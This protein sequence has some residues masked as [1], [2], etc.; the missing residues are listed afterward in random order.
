MTASRRSGVKSRAV[1]RTRARNHEGVLA[2]VP[3]D[4][5]RHVDTWADAWLRSKFTRL[6]ELRAKDPGPFNYPVEVFSEWRGKSFYICARYRTNSGRPEN[7]FIHR[8]ARLT[9]TGFERFDLSFF[10]H[11]GKWFAVRRNLTA[12]D[13]FREIEANEV[14]WP[15]A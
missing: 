3:D 14:F 11:T 6:L 7:D 10:R 5:R 13:C 1:G 12:A 2:R 9:M 8:S 4:A 15:T